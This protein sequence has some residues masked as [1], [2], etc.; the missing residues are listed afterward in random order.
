MKRKTV[1]ILCLSLPNLIKIFIRGNRFQ[2]E[3]QSSVSLRG[4]RP[5]SHMFEKQ[6]FKLTYSFPALSSW[7]ATANA[8]TV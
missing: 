5:T 2:S 8:S 4:T 1:R 7:F 6:G 3:R